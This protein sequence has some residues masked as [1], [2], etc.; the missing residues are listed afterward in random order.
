MSK[1]RPNVGPTP[2]TVEYDELKKKINTE[3]TQVSDNGEG[4]G[5]LYIGTREEIDTARDKAESGGASPDV[6][7][8]IR[9]NKRIVATVED[10]DRVSKSKWS[11]K[12]KEFE[13]LSPGM[14]GIYNT[15]N[16]KALY[17]KDVKG[18]LAVV[19]IDVDKIAELAN[20]P[21]AK[22]EEEPHRTSK[23]FE[24]FIQS[25]KNKGFAIND[26]TLLHLLD[27]EQALNIV[28]HEQG[29]REIVEG[30]NF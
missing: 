21:E 6:A 22:T 7:S 20:L 29:Q 26:G 24:K 13:K 4:E 12:I 27:A 19:D 30:F 10:I 2:G 23:L 28:N 11:F 5:A 3:G 17:F 16:R 18:Q 15:Y 1:E 25:L 14:A 9:L 8:Y